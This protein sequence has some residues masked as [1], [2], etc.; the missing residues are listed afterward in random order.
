MAKGV[1]IIAAPLT[2]QQR[3]FNER[4]GIPNPWHV[5]RLDPRLSSKGSPEG[6]PQYRHQYR[7]DVIGHLR[8]NRH[9]TRE[10]I[11]HTIEWVM[12]HQRGLANQLYVPKTYRVEKGRIPAPEMREYFIPGE[13]NEARN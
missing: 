8:F 12:P 1:E 5:V 2:R 10:G 3:R 7:Y 6:E 11:K 9:H 13:A 4:H